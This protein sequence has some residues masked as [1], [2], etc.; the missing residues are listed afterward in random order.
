MRIKILFFAALHDY[1]GVNGLELEIPENTTV[2]S[3]KELLFKRYPEMSPVRRTIM[4][5]IN[6]EYA[7]DEQIIPS[8]SEIALF[9][10]VSGG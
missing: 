1:A 5:A 3:L 7:A 4:A 6:H 9:P 2:A 8:D 10:P